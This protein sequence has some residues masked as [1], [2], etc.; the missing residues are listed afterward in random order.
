MLCTQTLPLH[1]PFNYFNGYCTHHKYF[2]FPPKP[3]VSSISANHNNNLVL[4]KLK[5]TRDEE[6]KVQTPPTQSYYSSLIQDCITSNSFELGKSIHATILSNGFSPDTFLQTKILMLYARSGELSDWCTARKLFDEMPIRNLTAWNTMILG[7]SKIDDYVEVLELFYRMQKEGNCPDKFTFPSVVKAYVKLEDFNGLRQVHCSVIKCGLNQNLVVG[8]SLVD[9]YV[10][11]DSMDDAVIAFDEI[12]CKNVVSWNSVIR[13]L[14]RAT[15]WEEAWETFYR[16]INLGESPDHF[17][18]ATA[19][20]ICGALR[21]LDRG[22]Q[23]HAK[24]IVCGFESD[25]F[26]GN[27]LI[28]MYAKCWDSESCTQV[29]DQMKEKDQVTWNSMISGLVQFSNFPKALKLFSKMQ[30]L[31]YSI[32]RFNLGSV[33]SACSGLADV[34][35]G[36][37]FHG[38]LVKNFLDADVIFGSALVDMY[39]K[40][41]FLEKAHRAFERLAERNEVSWNSLISGY[42]QDGSLDAFEIYHEMK[43]AEDVSPDSFTFTNLLNLCSSHGSLNQGK[44]IHA[45]LIRKVGMNHLIVE[46]ELVHMYAKC[47]ELNYA[48]QIFNGMDERNSYSWNSLIEGYEQNDEPERALQIFRLMQVSGIKPD[49][50]SLT[51]TISACRKLSNIKN[52]KELHGFVV[53]N[54]L[55]SQ[56]ILRCVLV[57][58]Y[59]TCGFMDCACRV[60]NQTSE[61]DVNVQNVM[62]SS[63]IGCGR[64]DDAKWVFDQMEERNTISWNSIL[65]GFTNSESKDEAFKLF[66]RMQEENVESDSSTL[67]TLFNFCANLPALAQGE[68]L[69]SHAIK[70]G[71][72]VYNSVVMDSSLVDMYAKGGSIERARRI[73]DNMTDRNVI[74]WNA[75]I[76]GYAKHGMTAEVLKL[77]ELM[78]AEGVYPNDS[79]FLSVLSACSHTGKIHEGLQ[80]FISMLEDFKIVAKAEHYTCMVDLLG[81]V[82]LLDEAKEVIEKMPVEPE[83]S[84]WGALLGACKL[85]QN[86]ELGKLAADQLFEMDP[87]NPGHY[88]LLSNIYAVAGRWKEVEEVRNLMRSRGVVKEPGVSWIDIDNETQTFHAGDKSHPKHKEIHSTLRSLLPRMK[89]LGYVPD[90]KFVLRNVEG[91]EDEGEHLLQHSERLAIGLG[92]ISL[93]KNSVIRVFKNLRI[94]GDCHTA[95]KFISKITGRKIIIRD[96]NRFHHFEN[97]VCSCGDFW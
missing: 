91:D 43:L 8:G 88:V 56:G 67:V 17:S 10:T 1:H 72:F 71:L 18:F 77:Y 2:S 80:V 50:F 69:H 30:T 33:I 73:F 82:G 63:F 58:M 64:V 11:F 38:Y 41:G 26:V 60:Y 74:S 81:R 31:G 62:L 78:Q 93:S 52:G 39:S 23:V 29:F 92:L 65:T 35:T 20:R 22:K 84:T 9:G 3:K 79:T 97:G 27:S 55:E 86:I 85:H 32:D 95:S 15:R 12:E 36:R 57:D 16:M 76:N 42:A 53:R 4:P 96:T 94:C 66:R 48:E 90:A 61:K 19:V 40:C 54:N 14:V 89:R 25:V 13:G 47:G 44:Q 6:T 75:M 5:Q 51:S 70:K 87:Q 37:E 7:Y 46:T 68:Q 34:R 21:S 59:A 28:D 49:H 83:I 24:L 45:H